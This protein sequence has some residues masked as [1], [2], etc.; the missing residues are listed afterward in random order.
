MIPQDVFSEHNNKNIKLLFKSFLVL[1]EDLNNEHQIHFSKL[2]QSI[3]EQYHNLIH[4]AD[5]FDNEK[6]T[7]LRK[8]V[9]DIGNE[10][11]RSSDTELQKFTINFKFKS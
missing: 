10:T 5:Y 4:Q 9:L 3:P 6:L 7:Y 8:K 2:K 11:L 1:I